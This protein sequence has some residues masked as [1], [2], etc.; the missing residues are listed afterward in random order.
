MGIKDASAERIK[1][2]CKQREIAPNTLSTLAGLTPS[3]VYSVLDP[4]RKNVGLVTIKKICDGLN[5]TIAE[6]FDA[7]VFRNLEQEVK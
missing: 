2:L 1:Q 4:K 7:E 6:F 3:T 5:I